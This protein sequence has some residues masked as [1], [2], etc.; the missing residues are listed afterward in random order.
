MVGHTGDRG[1]CIKAAHAVDHCLEQIMGA[2]QWGEEAYVIITAD[3]GNFEEM[4][5]DNGSQST[6]HSMND[7]P[8]VLVGSPRRELRQQA[9]AAGTESGVWSLC[10]VAPTIMELL[11]QS[12]PDSW[13]GTSL[14]K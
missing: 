7:V 9:D 1:A 3:H 10:D 14:L 2:I 4:K 8:V 6:Q 13:T 12:V 11:G 5:F